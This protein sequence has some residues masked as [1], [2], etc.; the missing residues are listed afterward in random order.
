MDRA[1]TE[2]ANAE[3]LRQAPVQ[4]PGEPYPGVA[5]TL[6]CGCGYN[7]AGAQCCVGIGCHGAHTSATVQAHTRCVECQG[8]GGH[9]TG[10]SLDA[11]QYRRVEQVEPWHGKVALD[12][13]YTDEELRASPYTE[14]MRDA[15]V[16]GPDEYRPAVEQ[17]EPWHGKATFTGDDGRDRIVT[18]GRPRCSRCYGVGHYAS[19]CTVGL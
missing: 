10:C 13:E 1:R 2:D 14:I 17:V 4:W 7:A 11:T 6:P 8:L 9:G 19:D 3:L 16:V 12:R 5:R 15:V 18:I